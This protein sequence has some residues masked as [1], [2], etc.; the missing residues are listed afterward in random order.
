[1]HSRARRRLRPGATRSNPLDTGAWLVLPSWQHRATD[2]VRDL[3][4]DFMAAIAR[5]GVPAVV[6]G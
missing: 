4:E 2:P 3:L 1:V 5:A 6:L